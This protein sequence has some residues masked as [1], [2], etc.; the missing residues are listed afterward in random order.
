MIRGVPS[1]FVAIKLQFV[2]ADTPPSICLLSQDKQ[3]TEAYK[4]GIKAKLKEAGLI[5][6]VPRTPPA[7][8]QTTS[9]PSTNG[10]PTPSIPSLPVTPRLHLPADPGPGSSCVQED[11]LRFTDQHTTY[12]ATSMSGESLCLPTSGVAIVRSGD[13][14]SQL[15]RTRFF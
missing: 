10:A 7:P 1:C 14:D 2:V 8:A 12:S 3:A 9:T 13:R 15:I 6:G 11:T 5:R 4:A